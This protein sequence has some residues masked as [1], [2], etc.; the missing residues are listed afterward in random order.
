MFVCLSV[1][2]VCA[3]APSASS[4][5]SA[6]RDGLAE[7]ECEVDTLVSRQLSVLSVDS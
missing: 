3:D 2:V 5:L 7:A 4:L 1:R 6:V